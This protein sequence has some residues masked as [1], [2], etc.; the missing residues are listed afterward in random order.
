[1]ELAYDIQKNLI[2]N[3]DSSKG[4]LTRFELFDNPKTGSRVYL[5]SER[6]LRPYRNRLVNI[7]TGMKTAESKKG[8]SKININIKESSENVLW[9]T[10][11]DEEWTLG[12]CN[13]SEILYKFKVMKDPK[14]RLRAGEG[15]NPPIYIPIK[16]TLKQDIPDGLEIFIMSNVKSSLNEAGALWPIQ[17]SR[18][19]TERRKKMN[20]IDYSDIYH[21]AFRSVYL[22]IR[23]DV[24][25]FIMSEKKFYPTMGI[26]TDDSSTTLRLVEQ[27]P[28]G[29]VEHS[30]KPLSEGE[31]IQ[32]IQRSPAIREW[33]SDEE[34]VSKIKGGETKEVE[35]K[36]CFGN[37]IIRGEIRKK[38][39]KKKWDCTRVVAG[40]LNNHGG[41]LFIGVSDAGV[42]T[43]LENEGFHEKYE[44]ETALA[45]YF[46]RKL[47][48]NCEDY[49]DIKVIRPYPDLP[50]KEFICVKVSRPPKGVYFT[51]DFVAFDENDG[52]AIKESI[53]HDAFFKK[54][55]KRTVELKGDLIEKHKKEHSSLPLETTEVCYPFIVERFRYGV[56]DFYEHRLEGK[57]LQDNDKEENDNIPED[58]TVSIPYLSDGRTFDE[59]ELHHLKTPEHRARELC[60][61]LKNIRF[62]EVKFSDDSKGAVSHFMMT[63]DANRL[64]PLTT[65][66]MVSAFTQKLV[67]D[68]GAK[69]KFVQ[70][71]FQKSIKS[72]WTE[73][74]A[75]LYLAADKNDRNINDF[76]SDWL[77]STNRLNK[78]GKRF[79]K[80]E[81]WAGISRELDKMHST[82]GIAKE[83]ELEKFYEE[84]VEYARIFIRATKP[85]G[86]YWDI[87]PY[88][89][90]EHNLERGLLSAISKI[91]QK[92]HIPA[93]VALVHRFEKLNLGKNERYVITDFLKNFN[94]TMI[95][96]FSLAKLLGVNNGFQ[97]N[98]IYK[99]MS[100]KNSWIVKIMYADLSNPSVRDEISKLPLELENSIDD[101]EPYY[102]ENKNMKKWRELNFNGTPNRTS[103]AHLLHSVELAMENPKPATTDNKSSK[104]WKT[105][106]S[107]SIS[108]FFSTK[109]PTLEHVMPVNPKNLSS[110]YYNQT[111]KKQTEK[112]RNLVYAFGNHCLLEPP[113]NSKAK[114][115][116]PMD[117]YGE[118]IFQ[119][120]DFKTGRSVNRM[121]SNHNSWGEEEI[122]KNSRK[123]IKCLIDYYSPE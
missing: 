21:P 48:K 50:R 8:Y 65:Y 106:N 20:M 83:D 51:M 59:P 38:S 22:H 61:L 119:S 68:K 47:G 28:A 103:I 34:L 75:D 112:H 87:A 91:G 86:R 74:S 96:Y 19:N 109:A 78:P 70:T 97:P 44:P 9:S 42:I 77:L 6:R 107:P 123:M 2:S 118:K 27:P 89:S 81:S 108:R 43:G 55:I 90:T 35:F 58:S 18:M 80:K 41:Y 26:T 17:V 13:G 76:F 67:T 24:E 45:D 116:D 72:M 54:A 113:K 52:S 102:W 122:G 5:S 36:G 30:S 31:E 66:D 85:G 32:F 79:T 82:K 37:P 71:E 121:I 7:P 57:I 25:H 110:D 39:Y 63:N 4:E 88:N 105:A 111:E 93:Y 56:E 10:R 95:R 15:G 101:K 92:Q 16:T 40:M 84:M 33:P 53:R 64:T 117:K 11:S 1:M 94:Y 3:I 73:V 104:Y 120:T 99:K 69:S 23:A 98:E 62:T 14:S 114:H 100:G 115:N 49:I 60:Y 12:L 29:M 46:S